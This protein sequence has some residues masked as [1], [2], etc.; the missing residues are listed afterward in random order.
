MNAESIMYESVA[1]QLAEI[2]RVFQ[3]KYPNA[4]DEVLTEVDMSDQALAE[5]LQIIE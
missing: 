4:L 5:L 2:V 3:E 1:V